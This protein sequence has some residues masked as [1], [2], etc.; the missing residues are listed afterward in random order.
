MTVEQGIIAIGIICFGY[1]C[2]LGG[3]NYARRFTPPN[4]PKLEK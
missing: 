4:P 3:Q 2:T 1:I